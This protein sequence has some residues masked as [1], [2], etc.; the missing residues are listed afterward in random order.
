MYSYIVLYFFGEQE[1]QAFKKLDNIK[2]DHEKRVE[3]LQKEQNTD[4]KKGELIE[5]NL[6][7]VGFHFIRASCKS[8]LGRSEID[9]NNNQITNNSIIMSLSI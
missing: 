6:E 5:M 3:D 7:L 8:T 2:K 1:K 9:G 4:R